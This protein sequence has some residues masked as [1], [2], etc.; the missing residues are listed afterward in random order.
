MLRTQLIYNHRRII[1]DKRR[2]LLWLL[3]VAVV[4]NS[5]CAGFKSFFYDPIDLKNDAFFIS[6][7]IHYKTPTIDKSLEEKLSHRDYV[8][9][10]NT[11]GDS[12]I[13]Q[14]T[15]KKSVEVIQYNENFAKKTDITT[16]YTYYDNYDDPY[17]FN[18]NRLKTNEKLMPVEYYSRI[19]KK[20]KKVLIRKNHA[21]FDGILIEGDNRFIKKTMHV[22]VNLKNKDYQDYLIILYNLKKIEQTTN[23][24]FSFAYS[25][26]ETAEMGQYHYQS[27]LYAYA[28]GIVHEATHIEQNLIA[29]KEEE[30]AAKRELRIYRRLGAPEYEVKRLEKKIKNKA[31][32]STY[33]KV[34]G[35][36]AETMLNT[37]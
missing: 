15:H 18:K 11:T 33:K 12:N 7:D 35:D 19:D 20:A 4:A 24:D 25:D 27:D 8:T 16:I 14:V 29:D 37:K 34:F 13:F 5:S 22:F 36:N 17:I 28:G 32:R 3:I 30:L 10:V 6:H 9:N 26:Y 21:I 23:R 31:W 2:F 1:I